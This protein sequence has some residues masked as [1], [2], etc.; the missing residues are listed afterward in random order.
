[1]RYSPQATD[2]T[3]R[4]R[5]TEREQ[6]ELPWKLE[7][8]HDWFEQAWDAAHRAGA[9]AMQVCAECPDDWGH[10][11]VRIPDGLFSA[12][13]V[14]TGKAKYDADF[15]GMQRAVRI[16]RLV[17]TRDRARSKAYA[18]AFVRALVAAGIDAYDE[19][20]ALD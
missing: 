19:L 5:C 1:M 7:L 4:R 13:L 18:K 14:K 17:D 9:A 8:A 2:R 11:H 10:A 6:R 3:W 15:D 20:T 12:W 16:Y